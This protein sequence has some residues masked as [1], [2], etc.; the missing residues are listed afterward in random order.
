MVTTDKEKVIRTISG[1]VVSNKMHKTV[2]VLLERNL[3]H[4]LYGKVVRRSKKV[5]V[6]DE[7]NQC[8]VNDIVLI[9]ECRPLSKTKTWMLVEIVQKAEQE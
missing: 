6:H 4:P 8:G 9:R 3:R 2:V 5:H 1:R 7:Q